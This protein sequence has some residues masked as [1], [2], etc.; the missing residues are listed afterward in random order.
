MWEMVLKVL[1]ETANILL[2]VMLLMI[3]IEF[4]ELRY[5]GKLLEIITRNQVSQYIVASLL[6]AIPGCIDAFF[7]V[8]LY[9]HGL[10]S[11]GALTAVMLSTAGDEAFVML[12]MIPEAILPILVICAVIGI[13]GGFFTD[14]VVNLVKLKLSQP[15]VIDVH[16]EEP[17]LKHFFKE[18]VYSHIIKKHVPKLFVWLFSTMMAVNFIMVTFDLSQ[19]LPQNKL[20]LIVLAALVGII[21]ESGPHLAFT[22]LYSKG[23]IPFSVLLVNTLSQDG[24]GLLPLMSYSL[25]D[26]FYVQVFTTAI[27]LIVG[28]ML[29]FVGL[30]A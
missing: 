25:K 22:I 15:C 28:L 18:H 13:I 23:L 6:G 17:D 16:E 26:T 27:A 9:V 24:H 19:F 30:S 11:F 5:K 20:L 29:F 3:V 10:V 21:P 1:L 4:F 2:V 12:A 14:K 8:S 7:V